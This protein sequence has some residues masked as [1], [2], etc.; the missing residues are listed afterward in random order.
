[1]KLLLALLLSSLASAQPKPRLA[2]VIDDFGL[3]YPKNVPDEKWMALKY[4]LTYAVMPESKW[5]TRAAQETAAAGQELILH[6]PFDPFLSLDL[7]KD[8]LS[9]ED[10]KK[11]EALFEKSLK[12]VP[13]IVGV[14]NHRSYKATRHR[15]LMRAFM[16]RLKARG[17]YYFLDSKVSAK[18]VAYEEAKRAG[19][20]AA[21]ND[22]FID[23]AEI[24]DKPFCVKMLRQ[25]AKLARKKGQAIAIGHHYF[26]GT[27]ECL[28]EELPKLQ[29]EGIE[30]VFASALLDGGGAV[31]RGDSPKKPRKP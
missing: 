19:L 8:E 16:E 10:L 12:Q 5:S 17:G 24:H 3:T 13:G 23:T 28:V 7:P 11:V 4:P 9:A 1:M 27:Y 21:Q 30:L 22:V 6:F 31:A 14:N 20:A 26:W 25:A 2:V 15:P 29:A 18:S